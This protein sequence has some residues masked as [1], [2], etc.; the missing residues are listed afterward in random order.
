M[1]RLATLLL[2][3]C[4][5]AVAIAESKPTIYKI[6]D[7]DKLEPVM[8]PV[9][10]TVIPLPVYKVSASLGVGKKNDKDGKPDEPTKLITATKKKSSPKDGT[11]EITNIK[12]ITKEEYE[13]Q[14]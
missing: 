5:L 13:V 9:S 14:L 6:N 2:M 11:D 10:S 1:E 7:N 3:I 12:Q 4:L 8:V